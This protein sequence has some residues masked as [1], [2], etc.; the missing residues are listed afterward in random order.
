LLVAKKN[1]ILLELVIIV[2]S[3]RCIDKERQTGFLF[4]QVLVTNKQTIRA[5]VS[6]GGS[7]SHQ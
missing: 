2:G 4:L 3:A 7:K 1:C 6:L 5:I